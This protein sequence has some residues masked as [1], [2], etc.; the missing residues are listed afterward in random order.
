MSGDQSVYSVGPDEFDEPSGMKNFFCEYMTREEYEDQAAIET[1]R[2]IK[3][4][5]STRNI[6]TWMQR[7][8]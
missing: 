4:N 3:V 1:E 5:L 6:C 2:A 8:S 7:S